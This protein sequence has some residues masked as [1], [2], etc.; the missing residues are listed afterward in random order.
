MEN[1]KSA[2]IKQPSPR[3]KEIKFMLNRIAK[4]PLS[5]LGTAI[6]LFFVLVAVLSPILAPPG[7]SWDLSYVPGAPVNPFIIPRARYKEEPLPPSPQ[8]PF[9]LTTNGFDI[10]YG[11][12]WGTVTAFRV[13]IYVVALS[14]LIGVSIGLVAGY[15]GGIVDEILM[16][17]TDIIIVFPGLILAMAF[18]LAVPSTLGITLK[19]IMPIIAAIT[20]IFTL[21][22]ALSKEKSQSWIIIG[23]VALISLVLSV[24]LYMGYM[25][26]VTL[27]SLSLTKLDRVLIAL[28]LVGWPGYARVIRGEVLRVRTEDYVEA[29]KAAGCSDFRII[30]RHILPNSVYPI[31][32]LASLDIGSV[33]LAAAALSFLGIGAELNFADW[34]QLVQ[35]AQ[36]H[37][38]G[39][40]LIQ[41]WYIWL[42]PGA[43]I[44]IFSLGWNLLGDAVRDIF[45]PTLRRR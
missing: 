45:D 40:Q 21:I 11:C 43:F 9:G 26:D 15:Y 12:I 24:M 14:L 19:F 38:M 34:G 41:Y 2:K 25:S 17:F 6:I 22:K 30:T 20:I 29:A 8:H 5:L 36:D 31:L 7:P 32:I 44:F 27:L 23:I 18:A 37:M 4:S 33:V 13:G 42:I 1:K 39:T 28:V 35:R 16:R 10:Y 3:I